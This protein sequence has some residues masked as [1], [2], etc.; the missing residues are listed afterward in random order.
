MGGLGAVL[1]PAVVI[2]LLFGG[3]WINRN[4]NYNFAWRERSWKHA[5]K[6]VIDEE[7]IPGSPGSW[8]IDDALLQDKPDS[9][10]LSPTDRHAKWRMRE[11]RL[12]GFTKTVRTPNSKVFEDTRLS[13]IVRKLP[14]MQEVWY[15]GLIYWVC[16]CYYFSTMSC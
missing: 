2:G 16:T 8:T 7:S 15:W 3:T 11:L 1:E 5:S 9:D 10:L 12:L 13:R 6:L 4:K 14:F